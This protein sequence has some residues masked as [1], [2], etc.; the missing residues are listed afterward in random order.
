MAHGIEDTLQILRETIDDS[1]TL[2]LG[3][4]KCMI[5]KDRCMGYIDEII[6][7]LPV[8]LKKARSIVD[9]R[10]SVEAAAKQEAESIVKLAQQRAARLVSEQ[11]ILHTAKEQANELRKKAEAENRSLRATVNQYVEDL[12]KRT[13][14]TVSKALNEVRQARLEFRNTA[15]K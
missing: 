2:P 14:E 15:K 1:F 8:E 5:D 6:N 13:E 3:S 10:G 9:N 4:D 12:L 11:E 7:N